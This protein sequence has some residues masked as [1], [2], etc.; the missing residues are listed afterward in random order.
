MNVTVIGAGLMGSS[1][2]LAMRS[3]GHWVFGSDLQQANA[4]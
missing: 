4:Q 1:M 3:K 2:G